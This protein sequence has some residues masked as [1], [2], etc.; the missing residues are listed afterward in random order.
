MFEVKREDA[1]I[2]VRQILDQVADFLISRS[3]E[4]LVE[5]GAVNTGMLLNSVEKLWD[6]E[7][8]I[9]QYTAPYSA[10]VEFG[11]RP[12]RP[13]FDPIEFWVRRKLRIRKAKLRREVTWKVVG[14]ITREGTKPVKYLGIALEE[15]IA[16]WS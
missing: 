1:E 2:V 8:I 16:R 10:V 15:A 7:G 4:V 6:R 9:V 3:Q 11:G 13:P 5:K 12:H 14:K